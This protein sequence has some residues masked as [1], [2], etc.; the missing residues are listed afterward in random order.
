MKLTI[1][2]VIVLCLQ[3]H[4]ATFGQNITLT[5]KNAKLE[6]VLNEIEKQSGYTF[7]YKTDIV[8]QS[9][10]V[11]LDVKDQSLESTLLL[12]FKDLPI[13]Y[14]IV[15]K[16]I[17]LTA[18]AITSAELAAPDPI[19][20]TGKVTDENGL[21]LP[22]ATI[23]VKGTNAVTSTDV[24]GGFRI[25]VPDKSAVLIISYIGYDN[26][27]IT[28]GDRTSVAIS[29]RPS[30]SSLNTV[31][32][33]TALGIKREARS[34][35]YSAQTISGADMDKVNPPNISEGLMGKVA[36]LNITIPNGVEGASTRVVLRGNNNL[37]GN[38][39]ALIVVDNVIIDNEP[40]Q[41]KGA[42]QSFTD[43][44]NK[45]TTD[46][47][48]P[49][50]DNGSFLNSLN[51]DD[52]ESVT[53]LKG[54]TAAAL[55]GAR[56]ANG[57]ML[58]VTKK[59]SKKKGFG[60]DYSY[61]FR[62]NDPY[63]FIKTQHEFGNGM[64]EDLYSANPFF[65]K[66]GNGNDRQEQIAGDPYGS[67]GSIPG[68]YVS[69]G[70][71]SQ[72]GGPFY[73]Y[74]GFPGDGS[75]W[76][77]RMLGQQLTWWDGKTRA[78]TPN[79]NIFDSFFRTGNT[80]T[81][82]ISVSGGGD[83]GTLRVSYTRSTN[84]AIT[85]NS[86]N[87]TNSFNIG[88]SINVS[89]KVKVDATASYINL[90]KFNPPNI[91]GESGS[92]TAGIG[93][94]YM[95]VY[96]L[97]ADYKPLERGLSILPDGSQNPILQQ[98]PYADAAEQYY[99][100]DTFKNTTTLTQNQFVGSLSLNAEI[101]P[102]LTAVGNVGLDYHTNQFVNQNYPT[103][104]AGLVGTYG[105]DLARVSTN[106][107]DG[108][109]TFHKNNLLKD[110]NASL[111]FGAR[112]YYTNMYDIAANNPG[113]FNY[114]FVFNLTNYNGNTPS[115][116]NPSE[117][118]YV[119]EIN[120]VYSLLN[121]SY[122]K[123]LF[124]DL[125]GTNDWSSTLRPTRWSYFYP[126]ASLSFVFTDAFDMGS[127]KNWL[128]YG[129]LRISE[130]E[131]A[132]AYL[133]YQNGLTYVPVGGS[134]NPNTPGFLTG[135]NLP[136]TIPANIQPQRSRSFEIG[137]DLGF[138]ND[139]LDV[140]FT[141]YNTYSDHQIITVPVAAS[142]GVGSVLINSGAL[143]NQGIELTVTG[144]IIKTNDFSWDVTLNA[145][146][147]KNKIVALEPGLNSLQLGSWFGNNGVLMKVDVGSDYGS[148]Y[149]Y[150]Y[151]YAPNGQKVVNLVYADGYNTGNGPVL[152]SQYATSDNFE[153]I[154]DATPKL[155]GGISQN[156]R[157]KNFSLYISADFKIG[158]QIWSGDY[159]TIM[160]QGMAPETAYE[161]DG[162]GL[163][164][165]YPDGT[166]ANVG[167]ILPGVTPV[168]GT[169]TGPNNPFQYVTNTNVVNA[170][171]KYAGNYQSWDNDPIV[172]T[173]SVFNDS[174]GKLRELSITYRVPNE[175]VQRTK[176]FQSLSL[177]LIGRNL[178]YL[179]T[180]LPDNI[181]PE[182]VVSSGNVQGI[183]FGG[184]PGVRSYGF[185]VKAGF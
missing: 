128:S 39:Q 174:W 83:L 129:K 30:A 163:P 47:S 124:L 40:V 153:K 107:M 151:K 58:I 144:K 89:P 69:P 134:G 44:L 19:G 20:I 105:Y 103:D 108:R 13:N 3:L 87:A 117:N 53:V 12:C 54:P 131:S 27:E 156:L 145:A 33:T 148:I 88:S 84:E 26:Q 115:A 172:R 146:H 157:Y 42:V 102:W 17:V 109:F 179:F 85:Y 140:N 91:Y 56:G 93:V 135:L 32:I 182:S 96:H 73:S 147:N 127:V 14:K 158:G 97:P 6:K 36:G 167:V 1:A 149:G 142:S 51:P 141:Y 113:P 184:L 31:E 98:N 118:R 178:F 35:G 75:S 152:G 15:Q 143:R 94:G 95:A 161:R 122:K 155:T 123:Y 10:K 63:R 4:A 55:Y 80:Q 76:G 114:P 106:N 164:Y 100:W 43:A 74:I 45:G 81:Q 66:D 72:A 68:A 177:S 18:K 7:W 160:G 133:P 22:G 136:A 62:A 70:V 150:G 24:N 120:T 5:N 116:L 25:T 11:S 8:K 170:W 37:Y 112:H 29:L 23:R 139:R 159:A 64:T 125:A 165:T 111:S 110:F 168:P 50:V 34:L 28:V 49:P 166:K 132:N 52:I 79:S 65:Y 41:P 57:V 181:N 104:A 9:Y 77:P 185:S 92:G 48:V 38:N 126:S 99:W 154:G 175:I 101:T 61:T 138:F 180:T 86:N 121:L 21:P 67:L 130:A 173:N 162:H 46:V 137:P 176:V 60:V 183:Q 59:G 71:T 2:L 169:G 78:Y 171:W 90:N 119:M 82:N 16:T